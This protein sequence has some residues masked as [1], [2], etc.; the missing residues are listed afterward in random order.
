MTSISFGKR[1][2]ETSARRIGK[3]KQTMSLALEVERF[4]GITRVKIPK[5]KSLSVSHSHV[6]SG[7]RFT[8]RWT[9]HVTS[10]VIVTPMS[11]HESR[12]SLVCSTLSLL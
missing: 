2:S 6:L 10:R 7:S 12:V 3:L 8:E 4:I 11:A 5:N 1:K 9:G